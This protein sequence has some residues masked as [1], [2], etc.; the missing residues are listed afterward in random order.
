MATATYDLI[1]TAT[2]SSSGTI[3]FNSIPSTYTDLRVVCVA[4]TTSTTNFWMQFNS[5]S[6]TNYSVTY[7]GGD[8]SSVSSLTETNTTSVR[9]T[10]GNTST[11]IPGLWTFDIFSYASSVYKTVLS[12]ENTDRNGSGYSA[13]EV[14]CWRSTSAINS[15]TLLPN[16]GSFA[17]GTTATLY[18]IKAA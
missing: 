9:A 4:T 18:G 16:T 13:R 8:G 5:D 14:N 3:T 15:I 17:S 7:L 2:L 6:G 1:A 10:L 12:S 11:T